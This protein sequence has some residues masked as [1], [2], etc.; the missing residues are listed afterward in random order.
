MTDSTANTTPDASPSE[1]RIYLGVLL[2]FVLSGFA[3]LL[4]QTAW[5]RQFSIVF[6]TAELAVAAVLAAYMAGLAFG[7]AIAARFVHRI[8][9]PI[10][11]YGILEAVIAIAALLVPL[12][13]HAARSLQVTILGGQAELPSSSGTTSAIFYVV[14]AFILLLIPTASMGATLPLLARSAVHHQH[15]IGSRIGTLYAMNTAGAVAGT[16]VAAFLLLPALGLFGTVLVGAAINA[17]VF[18]LAAIIARPAPPTATDGEFVETPSATSDA[19]TS[20]VPFDRSRMALVLPIMLVSGAIS[21]TN[22]V[23]WSRLLGHL[24]GA[25]VYAFATMLAC[26]L[27]GIAI[28]SAIAARYARTEHTA[29]RGLI[30]T[31]LGIAVTSVGVFFGLAGLPDLATSLGAGES[32]GFMTNVGL[33]ALVM[34]PATLFIGATFPFAV[35]LLTHDA[36]ASGRTSGQV[37]AWNT[38]GAI[39]GALLAGFL[40]IPWLHFGGT[41]R[42]AVLLNVG[43]ALAVFFMRPAA[44]RRWLAATLV[45]GALIAVFF[46]AQRPEQILRSSPL[47]NQGTEGEIVFYDVGRSA[48]ILV[49]ERDGVFLVR[50]N[51]MSEAGVTARGGLPGLEHER[52]LT[53]LPA[54]LRPDA[55]DMLIVGLGGGVAVSG[56]PSS[57]STIDVVEIE[58]AVVDANEFIGDRRRDDPLSDPRLNL[59]TNDARSALALTSRAYGIVVSQ[60]SHPWT[61][62]A[63]HLYTREFMALVQSR[64]TEGGI[65]VQ[66]MD[67]HFVDADLFR[68]LV[69]TVGD[70]FAHVHL[71]VPPNAPSMMLFVASDAPLDIPG[72]DA[73]APAS[74]AAIGLMHRTDLYLAR[75]STFP[76]LETLRADHAPNRDNH[77]VF[78]THAPRALRN[79]LGAEG[80][81]NVITADTEPVDLDCAADIAYLLG[82]YP[83][84]PSLRSRFIQPCVDGGR[85]DDRRVIAAAT[86]NNAASLWTNLGADVETIDV[87]SRLLWLLIGPSLPELARDRGASELQTLVE[88]LDAP[89]RAVVDGT[90]A[91]IADQWHDVRALDASLAAISAIDPAFTEASRLRASWR[92]SLTEDPDANSLAREAITLVDATIPLGVT[93]PRLELRL[94]AARAAGDD[95][96]LVETVAAMSRVMR[97]QPRASAT[98]E[99]AMFLVEVLREAQATAETTWPDALQARAGHTIESLIGTAP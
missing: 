17:V 10:L 76:N 32:A 80:I 25:S 24:L 50:S 7:A 26:F 71:Y 73:L 22:E 64:L 15:Q 86:L 79:R 99:Y 55:R 39:V 63:S 91:A 89:H 11:T 77:N 67:S 60:P 2:C 96:V 29:W 46:Q 23:L 92:L 43:L 82:R 65:F 56:V 70:V 62:G 31:Q 4:Y 28:G 13:L 87:D 75:R 12:G 78:A 16:L 36:S 85:A 37:Y 1:R 40:I 94:R 97:A 19:E 18:G 48:T 27:A 6:G 88:R 35:R 72:D 68:T 53:A 33:A 21:F 9:R 52:W 95:D 44:D 83:I 8:R 84:T 45:T 66:W 90:R 51:G 61:A 69:A 57:I 34:M 42:L 54:A 47:P 81:A 98:Q 38:V 58:A 3:A 14:V 93:W 30:I 41:A 74:N 59:V 20:T 49:L 5:M